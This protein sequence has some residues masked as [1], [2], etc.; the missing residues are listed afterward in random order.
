MRRGR[1]RLNRP[2]A[3]PVATLIPMG[4]QQA[5][6]DGFPESHDPFAASVELLAKAAEDA[7][8]S[9]PV[10]HNV[11][12]AVRRYAGQHNG[13]LRDLTPN[14]VNATTLRRLAERNVAIQ[15]I[16]QTIIRGVVSHFKRPPNRD[17]VGI[18]V[19]QKEQRKQLTRAA[20][21]MSDHIEDVL[22][23][24][25]VKSRNPKT[26]QV[27][28]WDAHYEVTADRLPKAVQKLTRDTLTLDKAFITVEH[29][30]KIGRTARYPVMF[31]CPEDAAL[32]Y[33][34]DSE[35]YR[36]RV[37]PDLDGQVSYVMLDPDNE[38]NAL[39]EYAW[40][41]GG[42]GIRNARTD[43]L[44]FGYGESETQKSGDA[45]VGILH[46][47]RANKSY[48]DDNHIPQGILVL[49]GSF[50]PNGV[51]KLQ[52]QFRQD[53]GVGSKHWGMPML[54]GTPSPGF[55]TDAKWL[56]LLD[57]SRMDMVWKVYFQ[58]C[59]ALASGI[60]CVAPEECGMASF[61]GPEQTLSEADPETVIRNSQ[62]R[63]LEL[64]YFAVDLLNENV[65]DQID[66][67]FE[68]TIQGLQSIYDPELLEQAQLERARQENGE[69][70]NRAR[71]LADEPDLLDPLDPDLWRELEARYADK[72][73]PTDV[74][75]QAAIR[76]EYEQK[77]GKLGHC[78]DAPMSPLAFQVWAQEHGI[79]VTPTAGG[80]ADA[81]GQDADQDEQRDAKAAGT[82][83]VAK[84]AELWTPPQRVELVIG[85]RD[86]I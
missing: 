17:A 18:R 35:L 75:Q 1:T 43:F 56:N 25:G 7:A 45:L 24:G 49:L 11:R 83:A 23:L 44:A 71:R 9:A 15:L 32:I 55:Q 40:S 22:L 39:R 63:R 13:I 85:P 58:L 51:K 72:W 6:P 10:K 5:T 64:V 16:H 67:D 68:L 62:R 59:F 12:D 14:V 66:E 31:W 30:R 26:G 34:C 82:E 42:L 52:Q 41:E 79:Q 21:A 69:S 84:A 78:Y 57:R 20:A 74:D 81:G 76:A 54:E 46:G 33:K 48:F 53:V 61:G 36:P 27:A 73:F 77:G 2:A 29:G 65:V 19:V 60:H 28:V 3:S 4:G 50:G 86:A 47:M 80:G 8:Q 38:W 70:I 37:R